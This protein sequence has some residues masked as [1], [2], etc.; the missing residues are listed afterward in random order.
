MMIH[1]EAVNIT[2]NKN[3]DL[4]ALGFGDLL[5]KYSKLF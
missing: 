4:M 3:N 1:S 5:V 2:M